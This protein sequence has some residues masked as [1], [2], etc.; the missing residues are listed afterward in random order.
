MAITRPSLPVTVIFCAGVFAYKQMQNIT[1]VSHVPIR[2][3]RISSFLVVK[4][5]TILP[6]D[7]IQNVWRQRMT[8]PLIVRDIVILLNTI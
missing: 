7:R 2:P 8:I 1:K 3:I 6:E 5:R 4:V